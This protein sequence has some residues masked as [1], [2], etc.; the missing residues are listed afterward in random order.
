VQVCI[1]LRIAD[2]VLQEKHTVIALT[3]DGLGDK[4]WLAYINET[5]SDGAAAAAAA[6]VGETL[7]CCLIELFMLLVCMLTDLLCWMC[8]LASFLQ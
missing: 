7:W 2:H 8:K 1:D 5:Y 6:P 4:G 3:F